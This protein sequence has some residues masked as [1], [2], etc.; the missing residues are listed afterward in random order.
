MTS[1]LNQK[2]SEGNNISM[3]LGECEHILKSL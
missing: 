3:D 1:T 2:N